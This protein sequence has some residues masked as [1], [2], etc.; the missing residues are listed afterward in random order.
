MDKP[1]PD[2]AW[3]VVSAGFVFLMQAGFM[4]LES[5]LTRTKNSIN[6]A[7]KNIIDFGISVFMFWLFG[8]ALMFGETAGG[9]IGTSHFF[10]AVGQNAGW[11][12]AFFLFQA[13]FVGTATTIVSGAVAER[14][15]FGGYAAFAVLLSGLIYPIFGHW[16][17]GGIFD[18]SQK[19][20]L[21]ALGFIDFAGSTVVHSI[22]GWS[23]LA[24][25]MMIGP[26]AGRFPEGG[27]PVK[28]PGSNLP[29]AIL[30]ALILW[31][32][33][34]GFNGGS[35]LAMNDRVPGIIANTVLSGSTG[36]IT[37]MLIAWKTRGHV[38]VTAA[39][40]GSLAG[41]VAITANCFAVTAPAAAV[42]GAG[43]GAIAMY[44]EWLLERYKIDDVVNVIPVHAGAGVWGTL[45]V[46]L[47]GNLEI[48]NT[49]LGRIEQIGV[50]LLGIVVAFL[51]AFGI[52]Y[53]ATQLIRDFIP[54]RVSPEDEQMGLNVT[55][56]GA[57][58]EMFDLFRAMDEQARSGDLSLRAPVEPFTEVGQIASRY[59]EVLDGLQS[60]QENNEYVV[61]SAT[62]A[63]ISFSQEVDKNAK[64]VADGV[65]HLQSNIRGIADNAEQASRVATQGVHVADTTNET[66]SKLGESSVEISKITKV[67]TSIARQTNLLA[68]NA[69]IEA[70]RAGEAGKGFA[71]VASAVKELSEET[72]QATKDIAQ[73]IDAIQDDSKDAVDAIGHIGKIILQINEFQD[74][75]RKRTSE[76]EEISGNVVAASQGSVETAQNIV[77]AA[78]AAQ[79]STAA[80]ADDGGS[81]H[82]DGMTRIQQLVENFQNHR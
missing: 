76:T 65:D 50:Q 39:I 8:F 11:L 66:V 58:T 60:A 1:L 15:R 59:N 34:F 54:M 55:E 12:A 81:Q 14:M 30:G 57:T 68:L 26:R 7:T 22:G 27:P 18:E 79:Q 45:C 31:F 19:G 75:V 52:A 63:I 73:K 16:C 6:V 42:I 69:T 62:D 20:W 43:G 64:T 51:W 40:N 24:L 41:L 29:L 5:G 70:A 35:T 78:E 46:G 32:G 38:G 17:W 3:V 4:C 61:R 23:A 21:E 71:V 74:A 37:A 49:G 53:V 28:I 10:T 48:L 9:W 80:A 44:G 77:A 67:I 2:I 82:L 56:H 25:V 72:A 33:W 13:M 36:L 47:F